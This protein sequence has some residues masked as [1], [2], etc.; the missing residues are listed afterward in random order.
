MCSSEPAV[1]L[2]NGD[3]TPII[4]H[5]DAPYSLI[6]TTACG[7]DVEIRSVGLLEW[8]LLR[9]ESNSLVATVACDAHIKRC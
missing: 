4:I 6:A 2:G 7:T 3:I 9:V 5:P 1:P 8:Q